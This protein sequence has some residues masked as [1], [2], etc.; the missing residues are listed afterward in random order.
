[1]ITRVISSI[2]AVLALATIFWFFRVQGLYGIASFAVVVGVFEYSRLTFVRSRVTFSVRA[3]FFILTVCS[4]AA[5]VFRE[6]IGLIV[7]IAGAIVFISYTLVQIRRS[8]E[9]A[10]TLQIQSAGLVGLI[11]CG[12]LPAI[13]VR[14]AG[15][16]D[17]AIW[18]FTLLAIVFS[19]DTMA[20]L[21]GRAFGRTKLLEPVSPKK[22]VEGSLGGLLGSMLAGVVIQTFF[23]QT[24]P[25]AAVAAIALVT[26]AFAQIGDLFESMLKR[27]ADVKDSGSIMPGHG[28][29]LDRLDGL[30]FAAPVF[31]ALV[32]LFVLK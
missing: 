8:D 12:L 7:T 3:A 1:M 31:Y 10:A 17:T 29:I 20:Y 18:F 32:K 21:A 14:T 24:A 23:L 19:G 13:V 6:D 11:Y 15:L 2:V 28:G 26:G 4:Y 22:T 25:L 30:L 16:A 9:L 5:T 27:L